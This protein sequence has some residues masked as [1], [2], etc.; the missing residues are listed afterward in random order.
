[1]SDKRED[2]IVDLLQEVREDQKVHST[3]LSDLKNNVA[4]NT[5]DLAAH[6][7]GVRQNRK[8]I[9]ELEKP[10]VVITYIKKLFLGIGALVGVSLGIIKFIAILSL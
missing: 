3:I 9:V 1:M 7:E 2:L 6:I 10:Y 8:R 5:S 4:T